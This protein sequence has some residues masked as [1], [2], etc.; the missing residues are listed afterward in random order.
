[1]VDCYVRPLK[2]TIFNKTNNNFSVG[3]LKQR[4]IKVK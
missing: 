1:M 4:G 3:V 2:Y